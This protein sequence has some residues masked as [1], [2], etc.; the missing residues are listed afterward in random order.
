MTSF[1]PEKIWSEEVGIR[2]DWFDKKLRVNVT[3][4]YGYTENIQLSA[5]VLTST[6]LAVFNTTNPADF[7][8][9]GLEIEAT[10]VPI[11]NLN[12]STGIGLQNA[13]FTNTCRQA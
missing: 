6:N 1:L 4:F 3:G 10:A 2:S 11:E 5:A 9:Y 8:D 12:I 7:R 13:R